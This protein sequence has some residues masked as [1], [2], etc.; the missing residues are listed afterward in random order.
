MTQTYPTLQSG[1]PANVWQEI[2]AGSTAMDVPDGSVIFPAGS[3]PEPAVVISGLAR[4]FTWTPGGR[5]I[6]IRYGRPGDLIGLAPRLGGSE[7]WGADAVTDSII[8]V[9][10]VAHLRAVSARYP[11]LAWLLAED[12]ARITVTAVQT[13][14]LAGFRPMPQ[15]VAR[16]LLEVALPRADGSLV[17]HITHQRLADVVGTAREVVTRVLRDLRADG[18]IDTRHGRIVITDGRRL[19]AAAS[20][21]DPPATFG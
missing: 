14:I 9:V 19:D 17:A 4:V 3:A 18:I 5:Q 15:R 21:G 8:A 11:E 16:H 7:A 12:L 2:L 6:T 10:S 13:M 20:L 1:M